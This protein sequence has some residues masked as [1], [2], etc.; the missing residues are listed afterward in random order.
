MSEAVRTLTLF[1]SD[2]KGKLARQSVEPK[3]CIEVQPNM[4]KPRL[5][6]NFVRT[7][8]ETRLRMLGRHGITDVSCSAPFESP[9]KNFKPDGG[10]TFSSGWS[11]LSKCSRGL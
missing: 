9:A 7:S 5:L 2:E 1:V 10:A 6:F 3:V 11:S 8:R 4:T